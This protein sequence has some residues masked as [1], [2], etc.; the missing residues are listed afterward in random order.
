MCAAVNALA[1]D[2]AGKGGTYYGP[3]YKGPMTINMFNTSQRTPD[4]PEANDPAARARLYDQAT[5]IINEV[6]FQE[7]SAL[8]GEGSAAGEPLPKKG[9]LATWM[10][11]GSVQVAK[12][13][14]CTPEFVEW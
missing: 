14:V 4:N 13:E 6:T 9:G 8:S 7:A 3:W 11:I 10:E 1:T 5:R 2:L 12:E